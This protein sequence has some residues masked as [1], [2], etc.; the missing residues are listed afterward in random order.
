[1]R[2]LSLEPLLGPLPDLDLRGIHWATSATSA[3]ARVPFFCLC[4][5]QRVLHEEERE[6]HAADPGRPDPRA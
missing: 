6:D 4:S 1:V 5:R 2:F 3:G